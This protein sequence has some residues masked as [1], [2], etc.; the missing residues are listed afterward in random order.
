MRTHSVAKK[1]KKISQTTRE[2]IKTAA[3]LIV[4]GI[5]VVVYAI[6]P[7][8][9]AKAVMGRPNPDAFR[10]LDS[11]PV[12]DPAACLGADLVCDTFRVEVDALT[13]LAGLFVEVS[14]DTAAP[15]AGTVILLHE[16]SADRTALLP[17]AR[18]FVARGY[19][20]VLYDQR[21]SGLSSGQYHGEGRL[22]ADDL[23]EVLAWLHIRDR[24]RPPVAVVG[25]GLGAE[26]AYLAALEE[27]RLDGIVAIEPYLSTD[28][29]WDVKRHARGLWNFPFFKT[30]MWWWYKIRSG[31]ASPRRGLDNLEA[32][33]IPALVFLP[34]DAVDCPEIA[35]LRELSEPNLLTV[36]PTPPEG[37]LLESVLAFVDGLR[38]AAAESSPAR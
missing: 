33:P 35:A 26:A 11:L 24:L 34:A 19:N 17:W 6:Y 23:E 4:V 21:A 1:K 2:V 18:Q 13:N 38:A 16:E 32:V 31:Y 8:T 20:V 27:A 36:R 9:R 37:Q 7:L 25:R 30:T 5:L 22:E 10:N 15:V 28:R 14:S 12:N 29:L 3:V